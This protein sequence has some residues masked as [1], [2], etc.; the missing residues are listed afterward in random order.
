MNYLSILQK[1]GDAIEE[2]EMINDGD[3]ILVGLSGG[4]DSLTLLH[5]LLQYK[6][7]AKVQRFVLCL[8]ML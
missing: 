7:I 2:F 6:I 8:F 5:C 1:V 3:R 4:K